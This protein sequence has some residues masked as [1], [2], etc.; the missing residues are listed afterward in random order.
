MD[1]QIFRK[2][3]IER[4]SSPE[5]LNDYVRVSSPGVWMVLLAVIILLTG[6]CVWGI[7]GHLDTVFNTV[8]VCRDGK[9]TCYVA[10]SDIGSVEMGMKITVNGKEYAIT[11]ISESPAAVGPDMGIDAYAMYIG[12]LEEGDWVCEVT[13]ET[14]LAD[15]TYEAAITV[16]SVSPLSFLLN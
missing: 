5:M 7:F 15:G 3:S 6:V 4:V 2:K 13:A 9:M 16:D 10:D 8:C 1:N 14:D 12:G 11:G